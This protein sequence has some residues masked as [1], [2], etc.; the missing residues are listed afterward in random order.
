[1][2]GLDLNING[3]D[4]NLCQLYSPCG[5]L[6]NLSEPQF[7][8]LKNGSKILLPYRVV[9]RFQMNPYMKST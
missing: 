4:L 6:F 8:H 2:D 9:E 7:S 3:L 1:M 5:K